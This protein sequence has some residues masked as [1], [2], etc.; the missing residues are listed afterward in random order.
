AQVEIRPARLREHRAELRVDEAP[1]EREEPAD[2]PRD[3]DPG[4]RRQALR[5]VA[6]RQEDAA[7]D[8]GAHRDERRIPG[9]Q[10]PDERLLLGRAGAGTFRHEA[11]LSSHRLMRR[12]TRLAFLLGVAL[13]S[14]LPARAAVDR[15]RLEEA[16]G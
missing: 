3:E 4:N 11:R 1:R 12:A 6:R 5:D 2:D 15:A 13:A 10:A 9:V 14:S 8:D 7:A 16:I